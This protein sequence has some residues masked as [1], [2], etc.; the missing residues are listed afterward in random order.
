MQEYSEAKVDG[1][2]VYN[3]VR[4]LITDIPGVSDFDTFLMNG[5]E[6]NIT[7]ANDEYATTDQVEFS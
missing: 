7:L 4:P 6:E 2:L 3:Q 1:V 5:A